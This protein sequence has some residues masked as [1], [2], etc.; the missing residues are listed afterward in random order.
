MKFNGSA[1]LQGPCPIRGRHRAGDRS[2]RGGEGIQGRARGEGRFIG[3]LIH[4]SNLRCVLISFVQTL[5]APSALHGSKHRPPKFPPI[6]ARAGPRIVSSD[7]MSLSSPLFNFL[8]RQLHTWQIF[9]K[10]NSYWVHQILN[11]NRRR[12]FYVNKSLLAEVKCAC[13]QNFKN[14]HKRLKTEWY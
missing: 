2:G 12:R 1:R 10:I 5:V 14:L 11:T 4:L 8:W 3:S 7:I 13:G 9:P 6:L